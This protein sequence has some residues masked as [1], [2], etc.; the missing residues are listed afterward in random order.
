MNVQEF[1]QSIVDEECNSVKLGS[2]K[3]V[4]ENILIFHLSLK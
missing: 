3:N 4:L 2:V 1:C